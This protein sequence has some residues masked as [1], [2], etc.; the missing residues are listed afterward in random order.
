MESRSKKDTLI[1]SLEAALLGLT[2]KSDGMNG[3][4][5]SDLFLDLKT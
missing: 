1:F 2:K 3:S 4:H 5:Q